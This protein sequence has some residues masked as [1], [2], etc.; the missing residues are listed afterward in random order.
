MNKMRKM[1]KV[2]IREMYETCKIAGVE[3]V[4]YYADRDQDEHDNNVTRALDMKSFQDLY[5][6]L[7]ENDYIKYGED[8]HEDT[9]LQDRN[10]VLLKWRLGKVRPIVA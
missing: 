4:I 3:Y 10:N 6:Y 1:T 8:M 2:G 7:L 9:F 5:N